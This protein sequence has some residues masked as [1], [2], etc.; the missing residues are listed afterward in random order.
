VFTNHRGIVVG[1]KKGWVV[2]GSWL[3][4]GE[5]ISQGTSFRLGPV[6]FLRSVAYGQLLTLF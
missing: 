4:R 5:S 3:G 1:E 6:S 2:A